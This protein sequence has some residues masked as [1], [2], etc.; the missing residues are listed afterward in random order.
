MFCINITSGNRFHQFLYNFREVDNPKRI[1]FFKYS[2]IQNK[3]ISITL[4]WLQNQTPR[5]AFPIARV[6][7]G[8]EKPLYI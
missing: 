3:K 5:Q 2:H 1:D 8:Q 7:G 4:Q 6:M